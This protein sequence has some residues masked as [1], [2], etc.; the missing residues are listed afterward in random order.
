MF[1]SSQFD[2]PSAFSGGGFMPS[3][4]QPSQPA[5]STPSKSRDSQGLIPVTVKQI[6][7]SYQSGDEKSNF[8]INGVDVTNVTVVGMLF[9]RRARSFND[10]RFHLDDG[11][12]R[13]ECVRWVTENFETRQMDE[14]EEGKYV[15][16]NGHLQSFQGKR[17]LAAFSVRPVTNFDEVTFHYIECIHFHLHNAKLRSQGGTLTQ[18]QVME[19]STNTPV[20]STSNGCQTPSFNNF[21]M[22]VSTDGLKGFDNLVLNYLQQPSNIEREMGVHLEE[23]ARQLKAPIEKIKDAI[24]ILEKEGLVYSSIDDYHYKAVEGC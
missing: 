4:A 1:S 23:I 20:H 11:T 19:S 24:E 5:S 14:I 7:E 9:D 6:S 15:R 10:I 12:G 22:D 21:T 17:Q 2:A 18:P 13:L 8:V 16:V 3:Q